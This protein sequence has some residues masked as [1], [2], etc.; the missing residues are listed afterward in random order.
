MTNEQQVYL[1][2]VARVN[3]NLLAVANRRTVHQWHTSSLK[4]N[5]RYPYVEFYLYRFYTTL[6]HHKYDMVVEKQAKTSNK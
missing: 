3:H 5:E 6:F 2:I 1:E 4:L